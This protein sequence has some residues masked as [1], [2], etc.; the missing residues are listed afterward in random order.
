MKG[1]A[2]DRTIYELLLYVYFSEHRNRLAEKDRELIG[3]F[4]ELCRAKDKID[5]TQIAVTVSRF[6]S[7]RF[8]LSIKEMENTVGMSGASLYRF[9][10]K[11]VDRL[12]DFFA[13]AEQ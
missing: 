6:Y 7:L 2:G 13:E 12:K 1:L 4:M 11:I 8:G 5:N 3:E 9:R 10:T